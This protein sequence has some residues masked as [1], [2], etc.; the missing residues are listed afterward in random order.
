MG[1]AKRDSNN[2][3]TNEPRHSDSQQK[4]VV[5]TSNRRQP[6]ERL[7]NIQHCWCRAKGRGIPMRIQ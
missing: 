5:V 7:T 3:T 1:I 2:V 6:R 4:Q